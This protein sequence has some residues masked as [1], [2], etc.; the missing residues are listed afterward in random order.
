V[1]AASYLIVT[2]VFGPQSGRSVQVVLRRSGN[3]RQVADT[4]QASGIIRNGRLFAVMG[5]L[6]GWDRSIRAGRHKLPLGISEY[7]ALR[8]LMSDGDQT[9]LVTFP[10]GFTIEQ[11]AARL[12]A[13]GICSA[14]S[15]L[16]ATRETTLLAGLGLPAGRSLEGYLF[17]DSYNLPF[18]AEPAAIIRLMLQRFTSIYAQVSAGS[19]STLTRDQVVILASV[20]EREAERD[21]ERPLVASVFLNRLRRRMYLQ[22]CATVQYVLPRREAVLSD[23]DTRFESPYNTYLHPGLPP[24]PIC[25]PGRTSLR[26]VLAPTRTDYLFFVSV[27]AGRHV[28]SRTYAEHLAARRGSRRRT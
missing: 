2:Q 18:E 20:V 1:L 23:E 24:G 27:G 19:P 22:S 6:L 15:F 11:M 13:E 25:N 16:A 3:L 9:A 10:E 7:Q 26:A 4:L 5:R 21:S 14:G 17:P 28:F 8:R 12:E